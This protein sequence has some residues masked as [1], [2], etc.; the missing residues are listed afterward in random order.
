MTMASGKDDAGHEDDDEESTAHGEV[1]LGLEGEQSQAQGDS[2]GDANSNQDCV[3][4][5]V[6]E[7][8]DIH[9]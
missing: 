7:D 2:S 6:S 9:R 8:E 3:N 1:N 4:I 5:I